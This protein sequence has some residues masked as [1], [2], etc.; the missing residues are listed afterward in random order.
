MYPYS[1]VLKKFLGKTFVRIYVS[2]DIKYGG[3]MTSSLHLFLQVIKEKSITIILD[4]KQ[5]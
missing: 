2:V 4:S 1:S 5:T 3:H